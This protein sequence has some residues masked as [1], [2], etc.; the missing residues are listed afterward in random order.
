[1][2]RDKGRLEEAIADFTKAIELDP[3][4]AL[5][6]AS[7]GFIRMIQGK[8]FEAEKDFAQ[9]LKLDAGLKTFV[10]E[11]MRD[12]KRQIAAPQ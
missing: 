9:C 11:A 1:M 10:Q 3:N 12:V 5:A 8:T 2:L 4:L 7:R 6:Y